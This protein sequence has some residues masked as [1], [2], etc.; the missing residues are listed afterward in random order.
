MCP[1]SEY[2]PLQKLM[3]LMWFKFSFLPL[4]TNNSWLTYIPYKLYELYNLIT[5]L[6]LIINHFKQPSQPTIP[7]IP[8]PQPP[9]AQFESLKV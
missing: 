4:T 2:L 6:P 9:E 5:F 1:F 3:L 7:P 8:I